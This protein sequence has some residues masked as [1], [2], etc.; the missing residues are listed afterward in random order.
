MVT[1][2]PVSKATWR[3]LESHRQATKPAVVF[4]GAIRLQG[5]AGGSPCAPPSRRTV[6]TRRER[7]DGW[8]KTS[9][10]T[11]RP[12]SFRIL[13]SAPY[14]NRTLTESSGPQPAVA[15]EKSAVRPRRVLPFTFAPLSRSSR[16]VFERFRRSTWLHA[17]LESG[18]VPYGPRPSTSAPC[19]SRSRTISS[20]AF[21]AALN[22]GGHP[23]ASFAWIR[24]GVAPSDRP[25]SP[26]RLDTARQK[27]HTLARSRV[28][29]RRPPDRYA[30]A[31]PHGAA[32][33]RCRPA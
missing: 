15:A 29:P 30:G 23:S 31:A 18:D 5:A 25:S 11:V 14:S 33:A 1:R 20:W 13:G 9:S 3:L 21:S 19:A 17:Q 27:A 7:A 22:N 4:V 6:A 24:A 12:S 16:S 26:D 2:V 8:S 10:R 32:R 28:A